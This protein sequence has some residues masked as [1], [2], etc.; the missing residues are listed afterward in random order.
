MNPS[1]HKLLPLGIII[2]AFLLFAALFRWGIFPFQEQI[3]K[4]ANT[5]EA[6]R[7]L[8]ENQENRVKELPQLKEQYDLILQN[9]DRIDTL[10]SHDQVVPFIENI[11]SLAHENTVE[12]IITNQD[13]AAKKKPVATPKKAAEAVDDE[14]SGAAATDK[15]KKDESIMGN[16]PLEKYMLLRLDVRGEYANVI[17]FLHQMESLQYAVDIVAI[18]MRTWEPSDTNPQGNTFSA[19]S[20]PSADGISSE[21]P[22]VKN[23]VQAFFD[24]VVYTKD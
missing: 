12:I 4:K 23:L 24:T 20:I 19:G 9:E 2:V 3:V 14:K 16:L 10:V 21:K 8:Q 5:I 15:K 7:A 6:D 13:Q 11:E 17:Q 18:D 1:I 22:A